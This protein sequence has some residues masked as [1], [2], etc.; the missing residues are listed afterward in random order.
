MHFKKFSWGT[1]LLSVGGRGGG[2]GGGND[3]SSPH[4]PP[5][6]QRKA[7]SPPKK[8]DIRAFWEGGRGLSTPVFL[9]C[10]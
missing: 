8:N 9:K 3:L 7:L 4:T 10:I 1:K 6:F 5:L 2:G